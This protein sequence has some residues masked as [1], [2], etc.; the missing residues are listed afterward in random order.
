MVDFQ[1][2]VDELGLSVE[3]RL[4]E[5]D[6]ASDC[7]TQMANL[8]DDIAQRV[9]TDDFPHAKPCEIARRDPQSRRKL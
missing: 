7:A 4:A 1:Y 8:Y 2:I 3:G 6:A 5:A 9:L